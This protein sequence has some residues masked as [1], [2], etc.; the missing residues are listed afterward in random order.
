M[1][2]FTNNPNYLHAVYEFYLITITIFYTEI[3]G[4]GSKWLTNRKKQT[5]SYDNFSGCELNKT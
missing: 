2:A 1:P 3:Q 4:L 5:G